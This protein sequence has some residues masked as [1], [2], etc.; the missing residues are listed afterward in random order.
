[1][2]QLYSLLLYFLT[3]FVILRLLWRSVRAPAYRLR[4]GERFGFFKPLS[5]EGVVWVHAVSVGEAQAA[6]PLIAWLRGE[7]QLP[8]LVTTTTPTGSDLVRKRLDGQVYHVY[9]PY[10]LPD[11]VGRFLKRVRPRL[12]IIMETEIWPNLFDRCHRAGIPLVIANARLSH[13]SAMRYQSFS[14]F[15]KSTLRKVTLIAAQARADADRFVGLG[16]DPQRVQVT[17]NIKFDVSLPEELRER[18]KGLRRSWGE[19]R[20]VWV[21]ASTHHGE[22]E[23]VLSA[24]AMVQTRFADALL[25]LVPRHP[26]RFDKVAELCQ[27]RGYAVVRRSSGKEVP[28]G[29][30]IFLGDTMGE[31]PLFYA[32]ADVAFVGGSL[33]PTGGHNVLEPAALAVPV[34]AGHHTDNFLEITQALIAQGGGVRAG[35]ET[36][37]A[38]AV[39]RYLED[40]KLRDAVGACGRELVERNRG[41]L[42][43]LQELLAEYL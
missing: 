2:R 13:D 4:W 14:S 35:N 9:A 11:V 30:A 20:P 34:I 32:A 37:L 27:K 1:M 18:A 41:A 23:I 6:L 3:P 25:I 29:T 39:V 5:E 16:M 38:T 28:G 24:F 36:E 31:L 15:T 26:E 43:K 12:A 10:D 42:T 8:V 22:E 19:E 7:K 17:G 33:V 40:D 21:A